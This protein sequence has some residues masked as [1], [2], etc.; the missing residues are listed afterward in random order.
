MAG[1][2]RG[3]VAKGRKPRIHVSIEPQTDKLINEITALTGQSRSAFVAEMVESAVPQMLKVRST[4]KKL[5]KLDKDQLE[6]I[7]DNIN[8]TED[9]IL[10][11][12]EAVEQAD[13]FSTKSGS[14]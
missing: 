13:I 5:Q 8:A 14:L 12:F 4:L 3:E 2:R 7:Q 11:A 9:K 1:L 6:A 10:A